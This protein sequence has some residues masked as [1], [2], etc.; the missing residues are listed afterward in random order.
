MS[1]SSAGSISPSRNYGVGAFGAKLA[2]PVGAIAANPGN[3]ASL[4]NSNGTFTDFALAAGTYNGNYPNKAGNGYYGDPNDHTA[5]VFNGNATYPTLDVGEN[6]D[7]GTFEMMDGQD[8]NI[9]ANMTIKRYRGDNDANGNGPI[10]LGGTAD[11][12]FQ[13]VLFTEMHKSGMRGNGARGEMRFCTS[14][15]NGQ[16]CWSGSGSPTDFYNCEGF[17]SGDTNMQNHGVTPMHETSDRGIS[18]FNHSTAISHPECHYH[19][20]IGFG[21]G[22]WWDGNNNDILAEDCLI[23]D[24]PRHGMVAELNHSGIFRRNTVNRCATDSTPHEWRNTAISAFT[25]GVFV[26]EDNVI[27]DARIGIGLYQNNRDATSDP[28]FWSAMCGTVIQRNTIKNITRNWISLHCNYTKDGC[29]WVDVPGDVTVQ[30][31]DEQDGPTQYFR[32]G[33]VI[34]ETAWTALGYS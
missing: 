34:D 8:D 29:H 26:I 31:N 9:W 30:D 22:L 18:K 13:N 27:D 2:V 12:L 23:E 10:G 3:L 15:F 7:G 1:V 21:N 20:I 25:S 11:W 6:P 24:I 14:S 16:F 4:I 19:D 33:G 32:T 28:T 17:K 5:V